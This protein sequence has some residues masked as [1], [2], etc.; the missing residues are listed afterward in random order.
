MYIYIYIYIY[1]HIHITLSYPRTYY[2]KTNTHA[3][4]K[5]CYLYFVF[6]TVQKMRFSIKDFSSKCDQIR[7]FQTDLLIFTEEILHEKLHFLCFSRIFS[8]LL[9]S[10]EET[11]TKSSQLCKS[12]NKSAPIL[13]N[14]PLQN[15]VFTFY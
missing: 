14:W 11:L 4:L 6:Y 3:E 7:S 1:I 8:W 13:T 9:Q 12:F 5:D 15:T 10:K 2:V